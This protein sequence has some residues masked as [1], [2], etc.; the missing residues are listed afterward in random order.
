M[1]EFFGRSVFSIG[2]YE[3]TVFHITALIVILA[4]TQLLISGIKYFLNRQERRSKLDKG[5]SYSIGKIA[6]YFLC[7]ILKLQE[8]AFQCKNAYILEPKTSYV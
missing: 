3:L 8:G 6:Q 1:K 5:H 7:R 2:N 4:A